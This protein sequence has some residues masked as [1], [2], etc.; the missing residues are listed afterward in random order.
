MDPETFRALG[1]RAVDWVA[2]YLARVESFPVRSQQAP[3]ELLRALPE[4]APERGLAASGDRAE[5][6]DAVFADLDRLIL[7]GVTHWQSPNFYAYFP[8][9][10]SGPAIVGELLSAGLGIQGMLWATSPAA[11]ELETRVLDWLG[12]AIGL[13][14]TFRGSAGGGCIQGTASESTL[15]AMVA[16]RRRVLQRAAGGDPRALVAYTSTQG[17]SSIV[18]AA[19]IAGLCTD[20]GGCN[21]DGMQTVRFVGVD[22]RLAMDPA[23]LAAAVR[24][25]VAAGRTPF[26]V[27]ATVGTT[28]STAMDPLGPVAEALSGTP[29]FGQG[30]WLHVDA[31][32]A[33]AACIC[34]EHRHL[35][36]G[37]EHADSVC[38]NPHKWLLTNFDCSS[39][40]TRDRASLVDALSVTPEYLRNRATESGDVIDYRDWQ[41]PLGRRFRALKL[42]LVLRHF[43]L[44][45]LRAHIRHH[46]ELARLFESLVRADARFEIA[47]PT[48]LSLVCFRLR[49]DDDR[50]RELLECLNASGHAYLS[51]T[52]LP[53]P[54]GSPRFVLRMAIGAAATEERHVRATWERIRALASEP[55]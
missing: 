46:V 13:P 12:E 4:H 29:F 20:A 31:A 44:D 1:H 6:W 25:D 28:S 3:G 10:A 48:T 30:G 39:F 17:H 40:W 19:M 22:A 49:G 43:G 36:T 5:S 35:L 37:V 15:V 52:T 45:G 8:C 9:S 27:C 21:E 42:W 2:D 34:P 24:A 14:A 33:G 51:H 54:A 16:A 32:F 50:N 55:E 53:D 41:I 7:P 38:F 23:A 18:K 11:T 47:A 26:F